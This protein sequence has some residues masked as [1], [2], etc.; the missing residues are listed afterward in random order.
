[1]KNKRE[2]K[3]RTAFT[4]AG[5]KLIRGFNREIRRLRQVNQNERKSRYGRFF[6]FLTTYYGLWNN[7]SVPVCGS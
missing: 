1:M 3:W 7:L 6:G 2:R 5:S 4:A